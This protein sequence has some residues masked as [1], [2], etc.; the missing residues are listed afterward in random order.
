MITEPTSGSSSDGSSHAQEERRVSFSHEDIVEVFEIGE[1][2]SPLWY[3]TEDYQGLRQNLRDKAEF[4]K[5]R[6]YG[7]LLKNAFDESFTLSQKYLNAFAKLPPEHCLRG[8]ESYISKQYREEREHAV[9]RQSKAVL[10]RQKALQDDESIPAEVRAEKLR[11]ISKKNSRGSRVF[12]RRIGLADQRAIKEGDDLMIAIEIVKEM[13]LGNAKMAR[14]KGSMQTSLASMTS[15][16]Y[17][18]PSSCAN[19][20]Q[21]FTVRTTSRPMTSLI[22]NATPP[23]QRI[24]VTGKQHATASNRCSSVIGDA[25]E[26]LELGEEEFRTEAFAQTSTSFNV[27]RVAKSA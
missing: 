5:P 3:A 9:R 27:S 24:P 14:R 1:A 7:I 13:N 18:A 15:M 26:L 20:N 10:R 22:T 4:L 6:G 23:T 21:K 16:T 17:L 25:L 2:E 12:A 19:I 11:S 8:C